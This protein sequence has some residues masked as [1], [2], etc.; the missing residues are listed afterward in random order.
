M[1]DL[2]VIVLP[3]ESVMS[4]VWLVLQIYAYCKFHWYVLTHIRA[5]ND[6]AHCHCLYSCFTGAVAGRE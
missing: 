6:A 1:D 2:R 4:G 5:V 3:F